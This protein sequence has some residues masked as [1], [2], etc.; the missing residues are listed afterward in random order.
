MLVMPRHYSFVCRLDDWNSDRKNIHTNIQPWD[1]KKVNLY[2]LFGP[3]FLRASAHS[4]AVAKTKSCFRYT[5]GFASLKPRVFDNERSL[6]TSGSLIYRKHE[7]KKRKEK[8]ILKKSEK[9]L[10]RSKMT[11]L[12]TRHPTLYRDLWDKVLW[13]TL[14]IQV[15]KRIESWTW[16]K[17]EIECQNE[18]WCECASEQVGTHA[19]QASRA[20]LQQYHH[21]G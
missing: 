2:N 13:L 21:L 12:Q 3:A 19:F 18:H 15:P 11:S 10:Q 4:F 9:N 7:A 16:R 8:K 6:T 17:E 14:H 1:N 5:W 20:F